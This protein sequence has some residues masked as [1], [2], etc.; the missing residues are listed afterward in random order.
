MARKK[1]TEKKE[2]KTVKKKKEEIV[3]KEETSDK[4]ESCVFGVWEVVVIALIAIVFGLLL[5]S[6]LVYN[7]YNSDKGKRKDSLDEIRRVYNNLLDDYYNKVSEEDLVN[8]AIMGMI[9]SLDDPYALFLSKEDAQDFDEELKGYYNG[10]GVTIQIND[11]EQII[12]VEVRDGSP[13]DKASIKVGDII[14]KMDGKAYN[15][16]NYLDMIYTIKSSKIGEKKEFELLRGDDVVAATVTIDKVD[17]DSVASIIYEGADKKVGIIGIS[18]FATNTYSQF[19][20]VYKELEE[21]GVDSLVIDL[22]FNMGGYISSAKEIASLFIEKGS[23][24][25]KTSD[26]KNVET[27]VSEKDK[28]INMPVVLIVNQYTA[29]SAE[30]FASCLVDNL[31][32]DVVGVTSYGKGTVQK[33]ME[34]SD[35]TYVKYT[36]YEW[37]TSKGEKIDQVGIVPNYI[38][39]LTEDSN[40][41]EQLDKAVSIAINK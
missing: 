38:V 21:A 18:N 28:V 8:G 10:L 40:T 9:G 12:V 22:R 29:S 3:V 14:T 2:D 17:L 1:A 5:G 36:V 19:L 23:V 33:L 27:I 24:V 6:F 34:L 4:V 15:L 7:K 20:K 31:G 32:V 25:Y 26:G 37:L 35:G 41:D 13:A 39:D 16:E 30:I 11:K